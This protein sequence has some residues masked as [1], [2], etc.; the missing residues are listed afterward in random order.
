[1]KPEV[2]DPILSW[3]PYNLLKG[4]ISSMRVVPGDL[5]WVVKID[6][7]HF[8]RQEG[9]ERPRIVLPLVRLWKVAKNISWRERLIRRSEGDGPMLYHPFPSGPSVKK[10]ILEPGFCGIEAEKKWEAREKYIQ[11]APS[12]VCFYK[13]R[14]YCCTSFN[15]KIPCS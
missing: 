6:C 1:M 13:Y 14:N 4:S 7:H 3:F 11:W 9:S 15:Y 10:I 5:T 2:W 8:K 12:H